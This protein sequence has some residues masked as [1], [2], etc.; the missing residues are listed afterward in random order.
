MGPLD[1]RAAATA[2]LLALGVATIATPALSREARDVAGV[3][4]IT[5]DQAPRRCRV[6]L[7]SERSDK[8]DFFV[9]VPPACR[10]AMPLLAKAGRWSLSDPTHLELTTPSGDTVLELAADG[11]GFSGPGPDGNTY[12]FTAVPA[13][14]RRATGYSEPADLGAAGPPSIIELA[15]SNS[16]DAK[17]AETKPP[18][19]AMPDS[20]TGA[21]K[22]ADARKTEPIERIVSTDRPSDL[23]G[24]YAVLRD[25][26]HDTGCMLTLDDKTRVKGGDRAALAPACRDQGIVI[27]DPAAWQIVRGRLVLIAKAGHA[28]HLD[29]QPDGTWMKDPAEGKSLS[30]K[31]L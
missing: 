31:K 29:K 19:G 3:W 9:A 4:D 15:T 20:N 21:V 6:M 22:V 25:K 8:G 24:R 1:L 30:L 27:F 5:R 13:A 2:L 17:A 18:A 28:T 23:A 14:E 26:T 16:G 7:N 10:H 12:H 11:A